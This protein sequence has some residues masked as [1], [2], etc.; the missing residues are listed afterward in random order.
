MYNDPSFECLFFRVCCPRFDDEPGLASSDPTVK[1]VCQLAGVS[2]LPKSYIDKLIKLEEKVEDEESSN[3]EEEQRFKWDK[4]F[5]KL[6]I[7][8]DPIRDI[9][10]SSYAQVIST[11][12]IDLNKIGGDHAIEYIPISQIPQEVKTKILDGKKKFKEALSFGF[13]DSYRKD[14]LEELKT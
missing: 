2:P 1:K 14:Q 7:E 13:G 6:G 3:Y 12:S 11:S 10:K 4:F 8:I 9:L 5:S